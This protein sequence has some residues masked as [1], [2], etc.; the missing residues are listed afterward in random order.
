ME[1]IFLSAS[2]VILSKLPFD[3]D[4]DHMNEPPDRCKRLPGGFY[5]EI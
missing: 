4:G 1:K 3:L 2:A 5:I